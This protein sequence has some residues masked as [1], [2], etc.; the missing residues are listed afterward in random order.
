MGIPLAAGTVVSAKALTGQWTGTATATVD[1]SGNYGY[2]PALMVPA[3]DPDT[4]QIEGAKSGD[5]IA[6]FLAGVRAKIVVGGTTSDTYVFQVRGLTN[7][8]LKANITRT[9]VASAGA[10]GSISPSGN[11]SVA[12]GGSVTFAITPAAHYLIADVL[13]DGVSQG[14]IASY[15]FSNVTANHT[16]AASF[17]PVTFTITPSAGANGA[18]VPNTPQAVPYGGSATFSILPNAGYAVADVLVDGVSQGAI[19]SYTFSNVTADH[20]ISATFKP[21][22]FTITPSAGGRNDHA[23]HAANR[24]LWRERHLHHRC[25]RRLCH[26]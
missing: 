18:I 7:A 10:N 4:P 1:S 12:Y 2:N 26:R 25:E 13:V 9:I 17:T 19:A 20:T 23:E 21:A 8:D 3:D 14:A 16:I 24:C 11:V 22:T 6:F 15:T 5:Q